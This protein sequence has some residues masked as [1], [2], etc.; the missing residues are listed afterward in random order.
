MLGILPW[1][2]IEKTAYHL[3]LNLYWTP[4]LW[5]HSN[6]FLQVLFHSLEMRVNLHDGI[7]TVGSFQLT[8][9]LLQRKLILNVLFSNFSCCPFLYIFLDMTQNYVFHFILFWGVGDWFRTPGMPGK[10][11]TMELYPNYQNQQIWNQ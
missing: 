1:N 10:Y 3:W 2:K 4:N 6:L 11:L 9:L 5:M 8:C 7:T